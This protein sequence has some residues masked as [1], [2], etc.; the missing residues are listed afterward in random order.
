MG[1]VASIKKV[2]PNLNENGVSRISNA[3]ATNFATNYS[4][5]INDPYFLSRQTTDPFEQKGQD[6]D[7]SDNRLING[8]L[9]NYIDDEI[10]ENNVG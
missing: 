4:S 3:T 5:N 1:C 9:D 2:S 8:E 7:A 10:D 6:E